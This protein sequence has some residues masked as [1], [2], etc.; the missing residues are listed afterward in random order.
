MSDTPFSQK[1]WLDQHIV[2]LLA[3]LGLSLYSVLWNGNPPAEVLVFLLAGTQPAPASNA[4][5]D[6]AVEDDAEREPEDESEW[7][8]VARAAAALS[9]ATSA[10]VMQ[11]LDPGAWPIAVKALLDAGFKFDFTRDIQMVRTDNGI[12]PIFGGDGAPQIGKNAMASVRLWGKLESVAVILQI[13]CKYPTAL[14]A[15]AAVKAFFGL[16]G[17]DPRVVCQKLAVPFGAA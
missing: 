9:R 7:A 16:Y 13:G 12:V 14:D 2:P 1:A 15:A 17:D 5:A 11:L 10:P 6:A 4:N 8:R 3:P